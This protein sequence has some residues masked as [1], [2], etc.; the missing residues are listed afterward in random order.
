MIPGFYLVQYFL[1]L[2]NDAAAFVAKGDRDSVVG[3][4]THYVVDGRESKP[5]EGKIFSSRPKR[6]RGT[7]SLL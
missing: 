3:I 4:A 5:G 1:L 6:S 2:Q 7:S